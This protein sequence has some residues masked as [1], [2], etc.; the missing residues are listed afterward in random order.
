M[1]L[2]RYIVFF[3]FSLSCSQDHQ[4][5][6]SAGQLCEK[7]FSYRANTC[8]R[9]SDQCPQVLIGEDNTCEQLPCN[10]S[11]YFDGQYCVVQ[12]NTSLI[13]EKTNLNIIP[14]FI[15]ICLNAGTPAESFT[16]HGVLYYGLHEAGLLSE[17]SSIDLSPDETKC[18]LAKSQIFSS[19]R[20]KIIFPYSGLTDL[21][22]LQMF[23]YASN[24]KEL[25]I[26]VEKNTTMDCPLTKKS[27]C[28]FVPLSINTSPIKK[29]QK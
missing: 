2:L 27:V 13:T 21:A 24:I 6:E 9:D 14:S 11:L 4:Q 22:P 12:P 18:H 25:I 8:V 16:L 15:D 10:N 3:S 1:R 28:K 19:Q 7:G 29:F 5:R 26:D 17:Q 20:T 23:E